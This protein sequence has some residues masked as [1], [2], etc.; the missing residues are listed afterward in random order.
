[1]GEA[2]MKRSKS[3]VAQRRKTIA[4]ILRDRKRVSVAELSD[5]LSISPLT[6]RRDLDYLE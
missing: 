6:V 5:R 3:F 2:Q 1:M 4:Q